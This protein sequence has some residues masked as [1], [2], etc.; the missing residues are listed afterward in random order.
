MNWRSVTA[1][2]VLVVA[3]AAFYLVFRG[4]TKQELEDVAERWFH[5]QLERNFEE[6][7]KVDA[8]APVEREGPAYQE[9]VAQV[10]RLLDEYEKERDEGHFEP[11]PAGRKIARATMVGGGTYWQTVAVEGT[12]DEPVLRIKLNFGYGEIYYGSLPRGST[13]YLLGYPLGVVHAI[14]LGTGEEHEI[15]ILDHLELRVKLARAEDR[16]PGDA[17]YKVEAIEWIPES[18]Q[19]RSVKWLF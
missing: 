4:P 2:I 11:D 8:Q 7:A 14:V 6:L 10:S 1:V 12:R 18:A 16:A 15:T 9:W 3:G 5:A 19:Y 17:K 13:V